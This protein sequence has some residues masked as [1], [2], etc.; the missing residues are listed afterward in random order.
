[1]TKEIFLSILESQR[2]SGLS[3]KSFCRNEAL[4]SCKGIG[5]NPREWLGD[6]IA[7]LPYYCQPGKSKNLKELLPAHWTKTKYNRDSNKL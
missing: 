5:V 4:A 3:I 7:K 2:K 6:V 1:M